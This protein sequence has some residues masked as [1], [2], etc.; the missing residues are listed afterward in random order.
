L[1]IILL[2]AMTNNM[3]TA[4]C[5]V[6]FHLTEGQ[7][8]EAIYPENA[9]N[10]AEIAAVGFSSFPD[11][12]SFELT[13]RNSIRDTSFSFRIPRLPSDASNTI[14][15]PR[16][17]TS[18]T[19]ASAEYLHGFVFCRQ[20]QDEKLQRGGEQR[21]IVVL[22]PLPLSNVLKPL[23]QYA[24]PLCLAQGPA[25]LRAVYE[26]VATWSPLLDWGSSVDLPLGHAVLR[27]DLPDLSSL[28]FE[29]AHAVA[30]LTGASS[31]AEA[32]AEELDLDTGCP[33]CLLPKAR[34]QQAPATGLF[35]DADIFTPF[36]GQIRNIWTLWEILLLGE[37][38]LVA[39]PTPAACSEAC[40]ALAS[41]IAPLPYSAD[42]RPYFTIHDPAFGSFSSGSMPEN[43]INA[44]TP[45]LNIEND[46]N[47]NNSREAVP[48]KKNLPSL[49]GVTNPFT[50]KSLAHWP[51]ILST[52]YTSLTNGG[53]EEST[54]T[55]TSVSGSS[56][57]AGT[58][59]NGTRPHSSNGNGSG[60]TFFSSSASASSARGV[61]GSILRRPSL[62]EAIRRR[63]TGSSASSKALSL[64]NDPTDTAWLSYRPLLQ[65]DT[66]VLSSLVIPEMGDGVARRRRL[67]QMNSAILRRHFEEL[68]RAVVF[69]LLPFITPAPPPPL[70][71]QSSSSPSV[72]AS[73]PPPLP[74]LDTTELIKNI[75]SGDVNIPEILVKRCGNGNKRVLAEFY[76]RL[77]TESNTMGAWLHARRHAASAFQVATWREA[78]RGAFLLPGIQH[79]ED[80]GSMEEFLKAE[81]ELKIR[82]A[83][84][85]AANG[86][87]D[88]NTDHDILFNNFL[89]ELR[90]KFNALP[91]DLQD[92]LLMNPERKTLLRM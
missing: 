60:S 90:L 68:G 42:Y 8:V 71:P 34:G 13:T 50:I 55:S 66:E 89:K 77:L 51:N 1:V 48:I 25:A 49:V 20:R 63:I 16:Y 40:S 46:T 27:V 3:L 24:G 47:N 19:E 85:L 74:E 65:P 6:Q 73:C 10:K 92:S 82:A 83:V 2:K 86:D 18:L 43:T 69:P 11:S 72:A 59:L 41:L 7:K 56:T 15:S 5:S 45:S 35:T 53:G 62:P 33:L 26:E 17:S 52:G 37:P 14:T 87:R 91:S 4:I 44:S 57:K 32:L 75:V 29:C 12:M 78:W 61:I 88:K 70:P 23:S 30:Q 22:S 54:T 36:A 81:T 9:L 64:L 76:K 28:P 21:A 58:Q 67:G 79:T 38:L 80:V 84:I 31:A 39:A